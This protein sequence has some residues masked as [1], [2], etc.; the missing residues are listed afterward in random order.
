MVRPHWAARRPRLIGR[1]W[2]N[3][4]T[5]RLSFYQACL[6]GSAIAQGLGK[7][8]SWD[9]DYI[10]SMCKVPLVSAQ[11]WWSN[12]WGFSCCWVVVNNISSPLYLRS[13][14]AWL[15]VSK[16]VVCTSQSEQICLW[17]NVLLMNLSHAFFYPKGR[18]GS[19]QCR[20]LFHPSAVPH[21]DSLALVHFCMNLGGGE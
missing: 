17:L 18:L 10:W 9:N 19:Y 15:D 5:V 7:D 13:G 1:H 2:L 14:S 20:V 21:H 3:Y 16:P 8:D 12:D 11:S 6:M 4:I